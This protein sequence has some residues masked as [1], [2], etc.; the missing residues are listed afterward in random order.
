MPT[1][2]HLIRTLNAELLHAELEGGSLHAEPCRGS[3]W[4]GESPVR[5][6]KR[7][8]DVCALGVLEGD[9]AVARQ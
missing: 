1:R 7:V 4:A 6:A 3:I 8:N 5:R 9:G 2:W